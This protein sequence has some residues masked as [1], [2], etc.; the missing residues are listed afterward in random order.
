[1]L[2]ALFCARRLRAFCWIFAALAVASAPAAALTTLDVRVV[3]SNDDAEEDG[4]DGSV[5]V[6]SGDLDLVRSGGESLTIGVRFPDLPIPA[7]AQI[8]AAWLQF[9]ADEIK[10]GSSTMLIEGDATEAAGVYLPTAGDLTGR[11]RTS[12][13]VAWSP[14][15]W[16]LIGEQGLAQRTPSLVPVIQELVAAPGWVAGDAISLLLSGTGKRVARSFDGLPA[17]A[18]LLHVAFE[19]PANHRPALTILSPLRGTTGFESGPVSFSATAID[20]ESGDLSASILWTSDL[21]GVLGVGPSFSRSDLSVGVHV[22]T[23]AVSDG[24][25]GNTTRTQRLTVFAAAN[26][27]LGAG[28]IG[29]CG[30]SGD[31]ATGALLEAFPGH[32]LG[33]GDYAYPNSSAEDFQNCFG[34][35]WGRHKARMRPIPGNE[36]QQPDATPYFDYFGAAAGAPDEGW[37][38]F[39][40]GAWHVVALNGVCN[41]IGGCDAGS[42]Q[43]QWLEADLSQNT[44]PCTLATLHEPRFSSGQIG[45][46]DSTLGLWQILYAHGV[47]VLLQGDDHAYERFARMSPSGLAEPMRGIRSFIAGSGG[48]GLHSAE[49]AEPHSEVRD[50]TTYGV[51]QLT[52]APTSYSWQFLGAG[53]GTFTDSGSEECVYEPPEVVITS[54]AAGAN[55]GHNVTIQLTATADDLEEGSLSDEIVWTSSKDGLLGTGATLPVTLSTGNHRLNARATDSMGEVGK[56]QISVTV[57]A[58]PGTGCGIGP[59]LVP[60]LAL[61]GLLWRVQRRASRATPKRSR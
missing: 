27:V 9:E 26:V 14:P 56:H 54:P 32:V 8:Q 17:G 7:D 52:L 51:L 24:Q 38:S 18:P 10:D 21:D 39:D 20:P 42:P 35:A 37:Y 46:D 31:D 1:V 50:D 28:D 4:G 12:A 33:L 15:P 5:D 48:R 58:P 19:D 25:G 11:P 36:Y 47:D 43:G 30:D 44:Q 41:E 59:E 22:L 2:V 61:L 40:V 49:E 45:V 57:A 3:T 13:S 53:P 60:G 6:E 16:L 23:A 29:S 34:P 55:I